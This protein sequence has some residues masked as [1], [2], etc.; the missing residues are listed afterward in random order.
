MAEFF[1]NKP[2]DTSDN[3]VEVTVSPNAP[4]P[5]GLVRFR[6]VVFDDA[7]NASEPAF[8]EVLVRDSQNPTAVLDGPRE[9]VEFGQSFKLSGDRSRDVEPGNIVRYVWTMVPIVERPTP[10]R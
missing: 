4:L 2:V 5:V 9:P 8:L 6:L 7:N 1:L 10:D 3:A